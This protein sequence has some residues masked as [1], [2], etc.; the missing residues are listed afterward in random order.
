MNQGN[1]VIIGD[2]FPWKWNQNP[3]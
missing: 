2:K 1:S 3:H